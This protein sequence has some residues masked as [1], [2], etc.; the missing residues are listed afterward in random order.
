MPDAT[1]TPDP[2][3]DRLLQNLVTHLE[4]LEVWLFG[5][6]AEGRARPDSDYDLLVVVPDDVPE[7]TFDPVAAWHLGYDVGVVADVIPCKRS[8]FEE[9]KHEIDSLPRA[10]FVRGRKL[11]ER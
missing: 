5:S 4:P 6:R 8:D 1:L 3:L 11:Y 7:E 10:A 9:E 2:T